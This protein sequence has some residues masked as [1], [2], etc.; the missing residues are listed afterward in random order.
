MK[1][2][3]IFSSLFVFVIFS[4][5]GQGHLSVSELNELRGKQIP[6]NLLAKVAVHIE[7]QPLEFALNEISAA[8]DLRF[9]Y[10][11]KEVP[12]QESVTLHMDDKYA[13]EALMDVLQK[14]NC[15]LYISK[16]G[17]LLIKPNKTRKIKVAAPGIIKG[18]VTD[19]A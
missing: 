13:V 9:N 4:S 1:F 5:F 8:S 6:T 16:S 14:T 10:S 3:T 2:R 17:Q 18:K 15:R 11:R 7:N 19:E 12:L